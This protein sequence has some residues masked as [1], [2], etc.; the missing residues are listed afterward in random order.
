MTLKLICNAFSRV[1]AKNVQY[2]FHSFI[3]LPNATSYM[4]NK[5]H[6]DYSKSL[7]MK[8][9]LNKA[10]KKEPQRKKNVCVYEAMKN[11]YDARLRYTN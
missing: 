3:L 6:L 11:M 4:Y 1:N 7:E 5:L 8:K 2:I 9:K 10:N